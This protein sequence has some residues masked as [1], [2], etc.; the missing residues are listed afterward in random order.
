M[1]DETSKTLADVENSV[2]QGS[3]GACEESWA[4]V[5]EGPLA[6]TDCTAGRSKTAFSPY[7]LPVSSTPRHL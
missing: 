5:W 3:A 7:L 2:K 6:R 4:W 1:G